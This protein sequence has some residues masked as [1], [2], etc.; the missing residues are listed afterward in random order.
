VFY[1]EEEGHWDISYN[2][3]TRFWGKGYMTEAMGAAM[4]YAVENMQIPEIQ[5]VFA[6]DNPS[7]GRV[8]QKLGFQFAKEIPYECNGGEILT[9][10]ILCKFETA[11]DSSGGDRHMIRKI[12]EK[13]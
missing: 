10:G 7:S 12:S 5:T 1:N 11:A 8:L 9:K 4:K 2:L 6:I 13:K 3:G